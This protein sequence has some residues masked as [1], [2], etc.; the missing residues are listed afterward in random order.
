MRPGAIVVR[1]LLV[2][3]RRTRTYH[4]RIMLTVLALLGFVANVVGMLFGFAERGA[5]WRGAWL[6]AGDVAWLARLTFAEFAGAQVLLV[7]VIVP[8]TA[9]RVIAE[10]RD[11]RTLANLLTTRL[12]SGEIIVGKLAA[13]LIDSFACMLG[14]VPLAVG[15][16]RLGGIDWR[17][18][19][20]AYLGTGS[21]AL[22]L[23]ALAVL[24]S[25]LARSVR[26][27]TLRLTLVAVCWWAAPLPVSFLLPKL[28]PGWAPYVAPIN[29][30]LLW[31]SPMAIVA[32]L[33]G[34]IGGGGLLLTLGWMI[35]LQLAATLV[36]VLA[37]VACLRPASRRRDGGEGP[38]TR[39]WATLR[40]R[41]WGRPAVGDDPM[42][43]K[44]RRTSRGSLWAD[45]LGLLA[46]ALILGGLGFGASLVVPPAVA[47]VRTYGYGSLDHDSARIQLNLVIRVVT[48]LLWFCLALVGPG[49]AAEGIAQERARETW[50]GVIA[51][52]LTGREILRAK[53]FGA[54]WRLRPLLAL[55]GLVWV[56]GLAAGAVHPLGVAAALLA[57]G[58]STWALL[59]LGTLASLVSKDQEGANN[60]TLLPVVVLVFAP[61]AAL[62]SPGLATVLLGASSPPFL[63]WLA[64]FSYHDLRG[65]IGLGL[66]SS[67]AMMGM[68]TGE[69]PARVLA[70][71]LIGVSGYAALGVVCRRR[72]EARFD[73]AVG[74]PVRPK[75]VDPQCQPLSRRVEAGL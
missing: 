11:R 32:D 17:L 23:A 55:I 5:N 19:A 52:P 38:L 54:A 62:A 49:F 35:G 2:A 20:L 15:L 58:V 9:G 72:A 3:A 7:L 26:E 29:R 12:S 27:A 34:I 70:G 40:I 73:E 50:L 10:E 63:G 36:F 48:G 41:V 53:A 8:V 31:S 61:L 43:W 69:G 64:L 74:R 13:S 46:G 71:Y 39:R 65:A 21:T 67:T 66:W 14:G 68:E 60:R 1:E 56:V 33:A 4:H 75:T 47:E 45:L 30:W 6:S 18:I 51:T 42:V 59:A 16:A 28:L 44:E 37:A 57:L 22:V 25:S 24:V